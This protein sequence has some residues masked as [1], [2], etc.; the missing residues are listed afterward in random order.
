M[1]ALGVLVVGVLVGTGSV[2][3]FAVEHRSGHLVGGFL[4]VVVVLR[5][6]AAGPALV[7]VVVGTCARG[8]APRVHLA[9][10]VLALRC[11]VR[12]AA[13]SSCCSHW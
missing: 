5:R 7:L 8:A 2:S 12:A 9:A 11:W 4:G 1:L 6:L 3:T 13:F 10:R